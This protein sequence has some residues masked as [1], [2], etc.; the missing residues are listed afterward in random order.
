[1]KMKRLRMTKSSPPDKPGAGRSWSRL[2]WA[3]A[4]S[5]GVLLLAIIAGGVWFL[6]GG[7]Y[8]WLD[9]RGL[10]L[11]AGSTQVR[12]I[13]WTEP[14]PL[15]EA[16]N[17]E[18]DEYQPAL[19]PAGDEMI[20]VR[21]RPGANTDL[22][23]TQ[24]RGGT[25][26][27]PRAL[28]SVNTQYDELSP[29][30]SADGSMLLFAS[31]RPGGQG[32][33][34]LWLCMRGEAG[35]QAPVNLGAAI[36]GPYDEYDPALSPDGR[37]L[38]FASSR[39]VGDDA[40]QE[41]PW[42]ATVLAD[43]SAALDIYK[44]EAAPP[45]AGEAPDW[46][47]AA[48]L[49]AINTPAREGACALSPIGDFLYFASN[50]EGGLGGFDVYR[51]RLDAEG[52]PLDVEHLGEGVNSSY[53]EV[54]PRPFAG[55]FR[56]LVSTNR[57]G[58]GLDLHEAESREVFREYRRPGIPALPGGWGWWLV[59]LLILLLLPFLFTLRK[60]QVPHL[61]TFQRA[62]VLSLLIH[63]LLTFLFSVIVIVH[64]IV[65]GGEGDSMDLLVDLDVAD[66][67]QVRM[68]TQAQLTQLPVPPPKV[69][70]SAPVA[71][72]WQPPPAERRMALDRTVPQPP[73][74]VV[75]LAR[76]KPPT[77]EERPEVERVEVRANMP[78]IQPDV[79]PL[80]MVQ[81]DRI[82]ANDPAKD[83]L[84]VDDPEANARLVLATSSASFEEVAPETPMQRAMRRA[85]APKT[86]GPEVESPDTPR[87]ESQVRTSA[88]AVLDAPLP[89]VGRERVVRDEAKVEPAPASG[90]ESRRVATAQ[91][92][93]AREDVELISPQ[94]KE[95]TPSQVR[96]R[97]IVVV[98]Q[99]AASLPAID[100]R[101]TPELETPDVTAPA[102][103]RAAATERQVA[104]Q[105]TSE[106]PRSQ[107]VALQVESASRR[108]SPTAMQPPAPEAV[109]SLARPP[110]LAPDLPVELAPIE[111]ED[112][113][114]R[115][116]IRDDLLGP[117]KL[118]TPESLF[119]RTVERRK[120]LLDEL[121][122][123]T[124]SEEAVHR[125][126]EFLKNHQ[127]D[128]GRWTFLNSRSDRNKNHKHDQALTGL[129]LLCFLAANHTPGGDSPYAQ[130]VEKGL[131]ALMRVQD[132][133]GDLRGEKKMRGRASTDANMYDHAIATLAL[134]EA[135]L[136]TD[137]RRYRAA[138]VE[139]GRFLIAAQHE[140]TGGWRYAPGAPNKGGDTSV[141][142][143]QVMALHSVKRLGA[144]VPDRVEQGAF[145]W[146]K[147]V[148]SGKHGILAGYDGN[149]P[150]TTMTAEGV[151][152][153]ILLGQQ[154][155]DGQRE[156]LTQ[157]L[158]REKPRKGRN[159]DYYLWYYASLALLH[160]DSAAWPQW[161]E[162]MQAKLISTQRNGGEADG[163]WE[164][165]NS[166]WGKQG[167]RIYS[168]AMAT[169][170]LEVY[171]RYL[172]MYR[173][174]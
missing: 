96:A 38:Y 87:P 71:S 94:V 92:D 34:D 76:P 134:A 81:A 62:A 35:W 85:I 163:S 90:T 124:R 153:R 127:A 166:R 161:N 50:R 40:R 22:F 138:A 149:R 5:G 151:F 7:R 148:Q 51:A 130:T 150:T 115:L 106:A 82:K 78:R 65:P 84:R 46:R 100:V 156:E 28:D 97:A 173:R 146:L 44:A 77:P 112:G 47:N 80:E 60:E 61:S 49:E 36:N 16:L 119:H 139:G 23:T 57:G 41:A 66:E 75:N 19:S 169:L 157:Y 167:G 136:M 14:A 64:A 59:L 118:S 116:A 128:D 98:P 89:D 101:V 48:A 120:K 168:T 174:D 9:G 18:V 170:T 126:L 117:V 143:W 43:P 131:E 108:R 171:Y 102:D 152:S 95:P 172:P 29:V 52:L 45:A 145:R 13:L 165:R 11:I 6:L 54:D 63:L 73:R 4:I 1:M 30:I 147:R 140:K 155:N 83:P 79:T 69:N 159:A 31:D 132:K 109:K 10:E 68:Q 158:L 24:R 105:P 26:S 125:A 74:V 2:H 122:G 123:S 107:A 141:F 88:P 27:K 3:M 162:A 129:A 21:G 25:W 93:A 103:S 15:G 135:A 8:V 55:G 70:T 20:F 99:V 72:E 53:D 164:Y 133:D 91:A 39:R 111:I 17:T 137:D 160:S 110:R 154:L 37:R 114:K 113:E 32:R 86:I 58:I 33:Y 121:G 104:E 144:E 142:G 67:M 56:L 12:Q 42:R